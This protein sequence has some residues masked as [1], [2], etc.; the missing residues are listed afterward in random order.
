MGRRKTFSQ[1]FYLLL[2]RARLCSLE[3]AAGAEFRAKSWELGISPLSQS[4]REEREPGRS[5]R[6]VCSHWGQ[7]SVPE[8]S[9]KIE[10]RKENL[11][12]NGTAG[13]GRGGREMLE[14]PGGR[15]RAGINPAGD[16]GLCRAGSAWLWLTA[17]I[18]LKPGWPPHKRPISPALGALLPGALPE[19]RLPQR[20]PFLAQDSP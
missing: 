20:V 13:A 15:S 6:S 11:L 8:G 14:R 7:V 9:V 10:V 12:S 3:E 17:T 1:F 5:S 18:L 4:C 2:P 19:A 16:P